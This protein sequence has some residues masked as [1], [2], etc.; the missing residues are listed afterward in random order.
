MS[1]TKQFSESEVLAKATGVFTRHGFE[2]TTFSMLT[3]SLGIGKQ[4]L[5]DAFGDKRQLLSACL[6]HSVQQFKPASA[7]TNPKL[8][9]RSSLLRFFSML[10]EDCADQTDAGCLGCNLL[11]E[12][13]LS[14]PDIQHEAAGYWARSE[15][16]L[17]Q[18]CQRGLQDGSIRSDANAKVLASALM[19][20][21]GGLRV[22]V[23]AGS[24][25][26]QLRS[27]TQLFLE[28]LLGK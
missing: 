20:W 23:R 4:S 21:M 17:M 12:K 18:V 25:H 6:A 22:S 27:S 16:A 7:L 15:A 13:G 19:N 3:D 1:R 5:Y 14:D 28:A 11:L 9:G 24:N 8:V 2:G 10:L 26:R